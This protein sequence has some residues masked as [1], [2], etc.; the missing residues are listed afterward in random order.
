MA[1]CLYDTAMETAKSVHID[2]GNGISRTCH[3]CL[4]VTSDNSTPAMRLQIIGCCHESLNSNFIL[5]VVPAVGSINLR[6][7]LVCCMLLDQSSVQAFFM[8]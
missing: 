6:I 7:T 2:R 3:H 5:A 4:F 1:I 8:C